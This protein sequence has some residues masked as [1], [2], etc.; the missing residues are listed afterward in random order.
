MLMGPHRA[1]LNDDVLETPA[2]F[3]CSCT[4]TDCVVVTGTL[5]IK[6]LLHFYSREKT[7]VILLLCLLLLKILSVAYSKIDS[8]A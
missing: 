8:A 1:G 5:T 4:W 6:R 2:S 3:K 7:R